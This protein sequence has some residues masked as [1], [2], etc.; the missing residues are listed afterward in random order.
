MHNGYAR[1][2]DL[3]IEGCEYLKQRGQR[4]AYAIA[5]QAVGKPYIDGDVR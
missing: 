1:P 2:I 5:T 3:K 4:D